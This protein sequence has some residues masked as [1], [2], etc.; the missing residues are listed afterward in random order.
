MSNQKVDLKVVLLGKEYGGKTSLVER[1]IHHRFNSNVPYQNVSKMGQDQFILFYVYFCIRFILKFYF[2]FKW[3]SAHSY[4]LLSH[5]EKFSGYLAIM[6]P[7]PLPD[8]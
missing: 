2:I 8:F 5:C 4:L 3:Y 7:L 1:F 6:L